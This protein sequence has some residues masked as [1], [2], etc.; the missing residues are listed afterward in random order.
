MS[1][2]SNANDKNHHDH[3]KERESPQID[4]GSVGDPQP[5]ARRPR[6]GGSQNSGG[7]GGS[8]GSAPT[9]EQLGVL[10]D[11]VGT[12]HGKG[13]NQ[14]SLPDF[15]SV[16]PSTGPANFRLLLNATKETLTFKPTGL[17]ANRGG[18]TNFNDVTQGQKDLLYY[19]L[20]YMQEIFDLVNNDGLHLEPGF[21]LNLPATTFPP[22]PPTVVRLA[23]VP[24]GNAILLQSI[25][26]EKINGPPVFEVA[27][28]TP[29]GPGVDTPGYLDAFLNPALPPTITID[30]VHDLSKFLARDIEGLNIIETTIISAET[31]PV[32]GIVNIPFITSN[33]D[34]TKVEFKFFIEKVQRPDGST[35]INLQYLQEVSLF[36]LGINWPH[37]SVAT[38][39]KQ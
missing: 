4:D 19:G 14:I 21:W 29:E 38:L 25:S 6:N 27:D 8:G 18:L 23:T 5:E 28:P 9:R 7:H 30:M 31:A 1:E 2:K 3:E 22:Q 35:Y 17:V 33:A 12:W 16:S 10:F 32:G 13:F 20:S 37:Y 26:I 15:D 36:F 24:H 11:L 34:A 39:R